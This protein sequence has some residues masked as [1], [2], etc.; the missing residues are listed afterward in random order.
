MTRLHTRPAVGVGGLM[1]LQLNGVSKYSTPLYRCIPLSST[2]Q[3]L[4]PECGYAPCL[5]HARVQ[6]VL[7]S[8]PRRH[9]RVAS[10]RFC[11]T[12]ECLQAPTPFLEPHTLSWSH[13]DYVRTVAL[14]PSV[15]PSLLQR[16]WVRM[17]PL[18]LRTRVKNYAHL[19]H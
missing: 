12:P 19:G 16:V 4:V 6:F 1:S 2:G 17:E 13:R 10:Q 11:A 9:P 15:F 5:D 18:P 3:L 14:Q 8:L 7:D